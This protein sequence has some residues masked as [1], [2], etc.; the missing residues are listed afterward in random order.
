[1]GKD[2]NFIFSKPLLD[3]SWFMRRCIILL[4][5]SFLRVFLCMSIDSFCCWQDYHLWNSYIMVR[6]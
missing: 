5:I 1:M 4:E 6:I 3:I 2:I